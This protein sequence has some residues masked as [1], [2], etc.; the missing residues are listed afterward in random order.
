MWLETHVDNLRDWPLE[1][2]GALDRRLG[3]DLDRLPSLLTVLADATLQRPDSVVE[4]ARYV[5][6]AWCA[7][8][9]LNEKHFK[10]LI[11][12][13]TKLDERWCKTIIASMHECPGASG[14]TRGN[15]QWQ[16]V[17]AVCAESLSLPGCP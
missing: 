4:C 15:A 1:T 6:R 3:S 12:N 11:D 9:S 17:S 13:L 2:L 5:L 7:G 8:G 14:C 10:A 16:G